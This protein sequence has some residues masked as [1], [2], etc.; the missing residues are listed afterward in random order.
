MILSYVTYDMTQPVTQ[1]LRIYIN[2]KLNVFLSRS[3]SFLKCQFQR[4]RFLFSSPCPGELVFIEMNL[5]QISML[6]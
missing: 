4:L 3:Q 6:K 1:V 2:P 5:E